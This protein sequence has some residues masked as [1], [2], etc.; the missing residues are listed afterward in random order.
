MA[1]RKTV[2]MGHVA[3]RAGCGTLNNGQNTHS[4]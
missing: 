2:S 1:S 4:N 3:I